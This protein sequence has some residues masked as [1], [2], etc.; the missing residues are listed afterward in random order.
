MK[1]L[2]IDHAQL[3]K[4]YS[5]TSDGISAVDRFVKKMTDMAVELD[6]KGYDFRV[7]FLSQINRDS[8]KKALRRSGTYDLTALAEYNE[9]ERSGAYII[10]LFSTDELKSVN[11]VRIQILKSRLGATLEEPI[12]VFVDPAY[13]VVGGTQAVSS[14]DLGSSGITDLLG[15]EFGF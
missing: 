6:L 13:A 4:Y 3:L 11:E 14:V 5:N 9:L 7:C 12:S 1:I 8:Y 15:D 2:F 10:T